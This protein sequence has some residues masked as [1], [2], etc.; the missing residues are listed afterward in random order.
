MIREMNG[1]VEV[2]IFNLQQPENSERL[3][4]DFGL[5]SE[6]FL[7]EFGTLASRVKIDSEINKEILIN[8]FGL[9]SEYLRTTF[10]VSS[11]EIRR[12]KFANL[13]VNCY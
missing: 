5:I 6:R 1:G 7:A 2:K 4:N 9:F 10:G 8:N 11:D 3:R 13:D 12:N